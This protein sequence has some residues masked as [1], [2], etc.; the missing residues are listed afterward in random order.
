LA[1]G[2][3]EFAE[4]A[5]RRETSSVSPGFRRGS[6]ELA[7]M[8]YMID[9]WRAGLW[10]CVVLVACA[11]IV[12]WRKWDVASDPQLWA[13]DGNVFYLEAHVSGLAAFVHPYAGYLHLLPRLIAWVAVTF[14]PC[15]TPAVFVY[16]S[17]AITL[18]TAARVLSPR[19]QLPGTFGLA[20][21]IV[22]VPHT[23]EVF[24]NP[25]NLQWITALAL[26][27]LVITD[28][29]AS[30]GE[31]G[32]DIVTAIVAGLTGP[33][34]VLLAPFFVLRA[35]TR[36]TRASWIIAGCVLTV[37]AI[38]GWEVATHLA[39]AQRGQPQQ[40]WAPWNLGPVLAGRVPLALFGAQA[41]ISWI[42]GRTAVLLASACIIV[43]GWM[44]TRRDGRG[45]SRLIIAGIAVVV[46][47]AGAWKV[48]VDT[49]SYGEFINGDRYFYTPKV[50]LAWLVVSSVDWRSWRGRA[51]M[52]FL[53][54]AVAG[55]W[56]VW[57]CEP[58]PHFAWSRYCERIRSGEPVTVEISPDWKF[59]LPPKNR[60]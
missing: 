10:R 3:E 16:G 55:A 1:G 56:P 60:R 43:I 23:G 30:K 24:L 53:A 38:Q 19:L 39:D 58:I 32:A 11:A 26:V 12:V 37:A 41:W 35:L 59:T 25:T 47:A 45:F 17:F 33:F 18:A 2:H 7:E 22:A 9:R 46:L 5:R 4:I 44:A 36:R 27:A 31:W 6:R 54:G 49:W 29:P 13:E 48:R 21:A 51:A 50:L 40:A 57:R 8:R 42:S 34:S 20:L 15:W 14:D 28:D 52:V